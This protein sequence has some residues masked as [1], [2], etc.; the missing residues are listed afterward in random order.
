MTEK[1]INKTMDLSDLQSDRAKEII[2]ELGYL[3]QKLRSKG[4]SISSWYGCFDLT[5][6]ITSSEV[7]NRGYNYKPIEGAIDD[8]N[9]PWFLYWEIVWVIMN[10]EFSKGQKVL[11]LG[12][13]SS[14]F[15]YYLSSKGLDVTTV[16]LQT[17]LVE[18]ANRVAQQMGWTLTNHVMNMSNMAFSSQFDHITSICV[19]EHIPMYERVEINRTIER[20]LVPGGKFS[21]TFD[22]RNPSRFARID[23]PTDVYTQFVESSG[24]RLRG[25]QV[26]IDTDQNYLLHPFYYPQISWKYKLWQV[27]SGHFRSWEIFK[28]KKDNDYTFGALFQEKP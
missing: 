20:S 18:N 23:T 26:F 17:S 19:F 3:I 2:V 4:L 1:I 14:L 5:G 6:E 9:F 10:T 27:K 16:D 28:S 21:I 7:I 11:D 25:N 13:S 12:G 24:L 8:R 22:Y 15:S